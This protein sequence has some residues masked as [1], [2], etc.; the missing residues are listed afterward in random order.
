MDMVDPGARSSERYRH[1]AARTRIREAREDARLVEGLTL[2]QRAKMLQDV[3]ELSWAFFQ[4][5]PRKQQLLDHR[6][7]VPL[8]LR[9]K[10]N[11]AARKVD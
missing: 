7:P 9:E 11:R 10:W 3:I 1:R 2:E 4:A 5:N 6:D 8:D